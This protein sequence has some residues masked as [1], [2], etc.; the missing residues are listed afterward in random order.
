MALVKLKIPDQTNLSE[1]DKA[2][3]A[4]ALKK[5]GEHKD[6]G[7][8]DEREK[9]DPRLWYLPDVDDDIQNVEE[10]SLKEK[11]TSALIV[12]LL[13]VMLFMVELVVEWLI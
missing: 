4:D 1:E 9:P 7:F 13:P 10:P 5:H 3:W 8:F 6:S 11:V 2:F 12:L